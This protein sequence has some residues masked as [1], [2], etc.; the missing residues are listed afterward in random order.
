LVNDKEVSAVA[1]PPNPPKP[2]AGIAVQ[3][4]P[5]ILGFQFFT[6]TLNYLH[7]RIRNG[8][9]ILVSTIFLNFLHT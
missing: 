1:L 9:S 7:Y 2:Q 3:L 5:A 4:I 8:F 6:I